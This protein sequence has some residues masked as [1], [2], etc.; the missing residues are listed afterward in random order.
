MALKSHFL[1]LDK[2]KIR[3]WW[4]REIDISSGRLLLGIHFLPRDQHK[5]RCFKCPH[6]SLNSFSGSEPSQNATWLRSRKRFM[7]SQVTLISF[8][9]SWRA[10][11]ATWV[12]SKK[13]CFEWSHL[14]FNS[15]S[16]SWRAQNAT[17]VMMM[18]DWLI[19]NGVRDFTAPV[20]LGLIKRVLC[21]PYPIQGSPAALLKLQITPKLVFLMSS[22]YIK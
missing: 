3:L 19:D 13:R 10:E 22:G 8:S 12:K 21:A 2:P 9:P 16:F 4:A 1:P 11:N 7:G 15:F 6:S 5:M 14:T 18:I 20:H 17:W